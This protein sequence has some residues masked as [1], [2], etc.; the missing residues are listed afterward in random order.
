[1][2]LKNLFHE[3]MLLE[4]YDHNGRAYCK[5][6][7]QEVNKDNIAIGIPMK[8]QEQVVLQE[9]AAY[10]FRVVLDDALYYF[11]SRVLGTKISGHV[12]L[13]LISWPQ[14]VERRQRR[15]FFRFPCAL[16][17]HYWILSGEGGLSENDASP[18]PGKEEK[19]AP[20]GEYPRGKMPL[21]IMAESQEPEKALIV[22]IS[23]GGLLLASGR[24]LPEGSVLA[25]RFFLHG[26]KQKEVLV[27]GKVVRTYPFKIGKVVR[28]RYGIEFLDLNERVRDEIIRYI[29]TIS[30]ERL[31]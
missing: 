18:P 14:K 25:L 20:K 30:R 31:R 10:T 24:Y 29:F 7:I 12:I 3:N 2:D 27:K 26:K 13:Y 4:V 1:M 8:M 23:G 17:A 9:G 5:S 16:D 19:G 6:I 22:N 15:H 11:R 21:N 28:Y